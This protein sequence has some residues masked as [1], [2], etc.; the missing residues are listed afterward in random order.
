MPGTHPELVILGQNPEHVDLALKWARDSSFFHPCHHMGVSS[1]M[2]S[3]H[4]DTCGTWG[5][6]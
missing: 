4:S 2:K 5:V 1:S 3:G 6:K